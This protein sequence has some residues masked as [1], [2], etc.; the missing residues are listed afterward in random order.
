MLHRLGRVG[1][2]TIIC[3]LT[4]LI[5]GLVLILAKADFKEVK[6]QNIKTDLLIVSNFVSKN[7][8]RTS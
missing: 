7:Q 1:N 5:L 6:N 3:K 8:L 2:P 4:F